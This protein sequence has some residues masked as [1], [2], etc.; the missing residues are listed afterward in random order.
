MSLQYAGTINREKY[1]QPLMDKEDSSIKKAM[2]SV[3][4]LG[5]ANRP[6]MPAPMKKVEGM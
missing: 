3:M 1:R 6:K 2:K 4:K 5:R